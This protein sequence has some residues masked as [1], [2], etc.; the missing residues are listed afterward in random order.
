MKY[1]LKKKNKNARFGILYIN[2][3]LIE[4]P[5][6]MPIGT[7]GVIKTLT[8]EEV[9]NTKSEIL[10]SNAFH[11]WLNPNIKVIKKHGNLHK[12][13]NW[14]KPILTDSGGFQIFSLK[15]ICKIKNEG[16]YIK[17]PNNNIFFLSPE[18]S[19]NI[20]YFLNSDINMILDECISYLMPWY[21][22]KNSVLI[23][24]RWAKRSMKQF[25]K[26]KNKNNLFG[27]IQGGIY[28]DLRYLSLKG[29]LKIGF[30]G[31]AIGGLAVGEPKKI[32][33]DI[34][35]YICPKIPENSP[36]Y[37]MGIGKPEDIIE[38][39]KRG[40][41]IFD[42]V[43]PTRHARNGNLFTSY[44]VININNSKYKYN[45][46]PLDK[47]CFCYTCTNYTISYLHNIS[48]NNEI[49]SIKLNTIHNIQ[50]YQKLMLNIR[51]SI[52]F[53]EFELFINNFYKNI[54]KKKYI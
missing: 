1:K 42:C 35:N 11:L 8:N 23:S 31:Y 38:S 53:N 9:Y 44:G 51:N 17:H 29:L 13:M 18:K 26:I 33:Y 52:K 24:L 19:I 7:Y 28:K 25:K 5:A 37:L 12:Y 14:K 34:L 21:Y 54:N 40:I 41:D 46:K 3:Y 10:L 45:I 6:F 4:T 39:V 16:I 48:I 27:I 32:M 50:Y 20:Q 43:I 2:N 47:N 36:R 22:V 30:N 49:L 15:K